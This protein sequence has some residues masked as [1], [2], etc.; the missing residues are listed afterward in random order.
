ML[1][2]HFKDEQYFR[3]ATARLKVTLDGK[4][5]DLLSKAQPYRM[6]YYVLADGLSAYISMAYS[7]GIPVRSLV[8]PCKEMLDAYAHCVEP[9]ADYS[10]GGGLI[11]SQLLSMISMG[12][13]LDAKEALQGLGSVLADVGYKDY[14]VSFLL[15]YV[16]PTYELPGKLLWPEDPALEKL[17]EATKS[18]KAE[19]AEDLYE[20]LH[21]LYYT[22]DNLEDDYGTHKKPGN[23]YLGYWSFE[24]A[25]IAKV[26]NLDDTKLKGSPYYPYDMLH[27]DP[28]GTPEAPAEPPPAPD[29][30]REEP[31]APKKKWWQF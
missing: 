31:A 19:A 18:N 1:R 22:R 26:M 11:Y 30:L 29:S 5:K 21:K 15:R 10:D 2:D 12:V 28:P 7:Q 16:Q 4:K 17:K 9:D 13:L 14:L 23:A 27:G 6:E 3:E 24:S 20:Y 8:A 25:A